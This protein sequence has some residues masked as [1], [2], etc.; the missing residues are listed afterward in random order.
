MMF[1]PK[2]LAACASLCAG[3]VAFA[4]DATAA[5]ADPYSGISAGECVVKGA[6]GAPTA[7]YR[8]RLVVPAAEA[9]A[10]PGA[11]V[12]L[13]VFLH[14]SGERGDDNARQLVHF[15]GN[16]AHEGFQKAH[17]CFVLA[18]QCPVDETWVPIDIKAIRERGA[19][20]SFVAEPTR[21]M[22]ALMQAI[23]EVMA[24]KAVD[25]ARVY[26][27][28]LSMGGFGAF[29]L[30]AR[31]PQLFAAVVPICGGGDPSTAAAVARIPFYIVH[32]A[33][34][35]VVPVALSRAMRE[36]IAGASAQAARD[37]AAKAKPPAVGAPRPM[38]KRAPNPMYREYE[39]VG[40]DSWTPAYRFGNDG[41]L[42]WMFA[43]QKV[44]L[45]GEASANLN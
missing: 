39:K 29:D 11:R 33:D 37:D 42:D 35:P 5:A 1:L 12:P 20:P 24:T 40:H 8:Y 19:T 14:G 27:T 2:L 23:D 34:D 26:L 4:Q 15:A 3:G 32:G 44:R 9:L 45:A 41:V 13:V 31:R 28:G 6:A 17:P 36:A 43:Q 38:P 30:A 7:T 18:M 25:P 10:H 16:C 21:A 22:R